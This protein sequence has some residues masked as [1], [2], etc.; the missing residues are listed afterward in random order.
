M[1]TINQGLQQ[2]GYGSAI[3]LFLFIPCNPVLA[4]ITPD[5]TLGAEGSSILPNGVVI[6]GV[7]ADLIQDGAS[8][9]SALFHSFLEF[10]IN[11]GQRVYF[12]N[13]DGI[14]AIFSRVTGTDPSD[15]LGT[16]GVNGTADLIFINPNG[17]LFGENAQLDI[18]GSFIGSTANGVVFE[19]GT[20]FSATNPEAPPLLTINVPLGLQY[21]NQNSAAITNSGSLEVGGDLTLV[22]GKISST[23]QLAAPAGHLEIAAVNGDAMVRD[24]LAQSAILFANNNLILEESQLVT[25]GDLIL[26]AGD[27]VRVRDSVEIPFIAHTGGNLYIQGN[28]GIDILALNHPGTPF[29]SGGELSLVSNGVISGDAHF[30]SGGQFSILNL[31]GEPGEFWSYYDPIISSEGDVVLGNYTGVSLKVESRGSITAGNIRITGPDTTL[32]GSDPDIAILTSSPA[33]ILRAG[34]SELQ[35]TPNVPKSTGETTFTSSGVQSSPGSITVGNISTAGE[36]SVNFSDFSDVSNLQLN[37]NAQ[38]AGNVLR[39]TPGEYFHVGS[40]F[41]IQ[42]FP[43]SDNT[44]FNTQFKLRLHGNTDSTWGAADGLV[45]I[46]HNDYRGATA[47][48]EGA[49]SLGYSV[50]PDTS[51]PE[52]KISD[53]IGIEFDIY[54]NSDIAEPPNDNQSDPNNNHIA[55][56]RDG[57]VNHEQLGLP[58]A[59]PPFDL[60][61]DSSRTVWIDY[62]GTNDQLNVFIAENT[63]KPD[64]PLLSHQINLPDVVGSQAFFGF[65]AATG[66]GLREHDVENWQLSVTNREKSGLG[67]PVILSAA[68]DIQTGSIITEGGDITIESGGV[69]DTTEGTL[70]SFSFNRGGAISITANNDIKAGGIS[71]SSYGVSGNID[72]TSHTGTIAVDG[73]YIIRSDAFGSIEDLGNTSSKQSGNINITARSLSLT[74]GARV[75]TGTLT[76]GVGGNLTVITSESVELSGTS[77]DGQILTALSTSN[78]GNQPAR[79][80]TIETKRLV[81]RDGA[82]IGASTAGPGQGGNLTVN[83]SEFVELIGTAPDGFPSGLST[84]TIGTGDAGNLTINTRRLVIRDGA[85]V[86]SST[87]REGQGG[88]LTVNASESIELNGISRDGFASGLYAQAFG[89]GDA[90]NLIVNHTQN[91]N[92]RDGAKI[93]VATGTAADARVPNVPS[94]DAGD[95]VVLPT[96]ESDATGNAGNAEITADFIRLNN[97]AAIIAET[98]SSEGGNITLNVNDILL[99]RHNSSISTTAGTAQAGGNGGN[100]RINSPFIV[101]LPWENSDITAN[102][103]FGNG[104]RVDIT[105]N[106]IYGLE[107]RPRLTPLSDITA[108]SEFGEQG[109]VELDTLE[110]DPDTGLLQ[111][112][113]PASPP[114]FVNFCQGRSDQTP[115]HFI[116]SG[117]GGVPPTISQVTGTDNVWEDLRPLTPNSDSRPAKIEPVSQRSSRTIIEAQGWIKLPDGTVVLTAEAPNVTPNTGWQNPI[118]CQSAVE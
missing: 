4:Q 94:F 81:V 35:N 75:L 27:T 37:N 54:E 72:L 6:D 11:E 16:L 78:A 85:V 55:L 117:R 59:S 84:D 92:I 62:N 61:G 63:T 118:N 36:S 74:N 50:L 8:R 42:P 14:E 60:D 41:F 98:D 80:L 113:A 48:G 110:I 83:A 97:Q 51:N 29:Q 106:K 115:S 88:N 91:L 13:P 107:F 66:G 87:F 76:N 114:D 56:V 12:A 86:S 46:V 30:A 112:P 57:S 25:A 9:G 70:D 99:L 40:V 108:S 103:F 2:I 47:L 39:L 45:F 64:Q 105:A 26:L 44:S 33:L 100:I 102:A 71:A 93:T 43:I 21:G 109:V 7:T 23:G 24:G 18:R 111:L 49:N 58:L 10:N 101:G 89:D 104:G 67:G 3:A 73:T 90:G 19:N 15:I 65:S 5:S 38:Q 95:D 34:L 31:A 28:Q 17:I 53:S 68:D 116:I 32:S 69:I 52:A 82:V 96:F 20:T 79:N 22:G 77:P 1:M